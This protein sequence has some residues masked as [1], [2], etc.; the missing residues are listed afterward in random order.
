MPRSGGMH[1][2][3]DFGGVWNTGFLVVLCF[4]V[5]PLS[6]SLEGVRKFK[7]AMRFFGKEGGW[8]GEK[9]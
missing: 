7:I 9:Y 5:E 8:A 2:F 1:S 6:Q 4:S 3:S